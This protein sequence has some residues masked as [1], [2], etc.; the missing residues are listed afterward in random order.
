MF[1][2]DTTGS[3]FDVIKA[4]REFF[5]QIVESFLRLKSGVRIG[6]CAIGD[7]CD[8]FTEYAVDCL[9][10]SQDSREIRYWFYDLHGTLG[11]DFP[12][13][14]ELFLQ[15]IQGMDWRDDSEQVVF[16]VG[17]SVPHPNTY[18]DKNLYWFDEL[19]DL[20]TAR[21]NL[22]LHVIHPLFAAKSPDEI[23]QAKDFLSEIAWR[24]GGSYVE[25][26]RI[27]HVF[28]YLLAIFV[29]GAG[30]P[31]KFK[32]FKNAVMSVPTMEP[33]KI[34][35]VEDLDVRKKIDKETPLDPTKTYPWWLK[36]E[37]KGKPL[38]Q[39]N[40]KIE[41]WIRNYNSSYLTLMFTIT[42]LLYNSNTI[43]S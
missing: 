20:V 34:K 2:F 4:V 1:A 18:T 25:L 3:M 19:Q 29:K 36:T 6:L 22:K 5:V 43:F 24:T 42:S 27:Y 28:D 30:G 11:G 35:L 16:L 9:D 31:E 33:W 41:I 7:Y 38:F 21:P 17:D 10:F 14:Y 23:A 8:S 32:A 13:A 40:D 39:F 26:T 37:Q 15:Q 12:E